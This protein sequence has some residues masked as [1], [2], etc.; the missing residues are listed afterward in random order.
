M[1]TLLEVYG[2]VH[3]GVCEIIENQ[4]RHLFLGVCREPDG[5]DHDC[6]TAV[7]SMVVGLK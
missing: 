1:Q 7:I 6:R 3:D 5:S 2:L 4:G